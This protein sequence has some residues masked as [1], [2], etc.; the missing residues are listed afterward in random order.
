MYILNAF[1]S[2]Q[3]YEILRNVN[4][5][6]GLKFKLHDTNVFSNRI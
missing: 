4:Y 3:G 5:K 2:Q 6:L 1:K